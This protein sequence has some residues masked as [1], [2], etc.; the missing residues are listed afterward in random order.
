MLKFPSL[1]T[2][3]L[4]GKGKFEPALHTIHTARWDK[5]TIRGSITAKQLTTKM[6]GLMEWFII[7]SLDSVG[8]LCSTRWFSLR[9][10]H[11]VAVRWW[12]GPWSS[13]GLPGL[14]IWD[15]SLPWLALDVGSEFSCGC[16]PEYLQVAS[17][18][19]RGFSQVLDESNFPISK[20]SKRT[21][22]K[23]LWLL[24]T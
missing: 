5:G 1:G 4:G 6:S 7:I 9:A 10:S 8:W 17:L 18:C 22:R 12:P 23:L 20:S 16:Q 21:K 15:G 3:G 13:E 19:V 2:A 14:D 11:V 24:M